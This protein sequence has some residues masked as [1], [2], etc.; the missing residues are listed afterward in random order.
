M[1]GVLQVVQGLQIA[2]LGLSFPDEGDV[3]GGLIHAINM[4]E[5]VGLVIK[6]GAG[7]HDGKPHRCAGKIKVLAK[8]SNIEQYIPVSSFTVFEFGSLKDSGN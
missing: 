4:Q 7:G 5:L 8:V 2:E 3:H 6:K 1:G